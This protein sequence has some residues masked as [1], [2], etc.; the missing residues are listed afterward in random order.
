MD[1]EK[2]EVVGHAYGTSSFLNLIERIGSVGGATGDYNPDLVPCQNPALRQDIVDILTPEF[3][4]TLFEHSIFLAKQTIDLI[5]EIFEQGWIASDGRELPEFD[6]ELREKVIETASLAQIVNSA[7][8]LKFTLGETIKWEVMSS[9]YIYRRYANALKNIT[10]VYFQYPSN[11]L[12]YSEI[13][14]SNFAT[15]IV[16]FLT[17]H[18]AD[19]QRSNRFKTDMLSPDLTT[20]QKVI[21]RNA[22]QC[23]PRTHVNYPDGMPLLMKES[24]TA[25]EK[26]YLRFYELMFV[27]KGGVNKTMVIPDGLPKKVKVAAAKEYKRGMLS[28]GGI[29]SVTGVKVPDTFKELVTPIPD[30][31]LDVI[32]SHLSEDSKVT[33]QKIEGEAASGALGGEAPVVNKEEDDESVVRLKPILAEFLKDVYD[34]FFDIKSDDYEIEFKEEPDEVVGMDAEGTQDEDQTEAHSIGDDYVSYTVQMLPSGVYTYPE[35]EVKSD[36][37]SRDDV[38]AMCNRSVNSFYLEMD[39]SFRPDLVDI[40]EGIGHGAIVGYNE[41]TGAD[42]TKLYVKRAVASQIGKNIRVSPYFNKIQ[43]AGRK[44]LSVRNCAILKPTTKS[45]AEASGLFSGGTQDEES[46]ESE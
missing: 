46:E 13:T 1:N 25:L 10:E 15:E 28:L 29:I 17:Q 21:A 24:Q 12:L 7:Y 41:T 27:H 35:R 2:V 26:L 6:A 40:T 43:L 38:R 39:H 5:R 3:R 20:T 34:V 44:L 16:G 22:V 31:H 42:I 23:M 8:L 14:E 9:N 11:P 19:V 30:L 32:N 4:E 33:K 45:R 37:Y 36:Y 18:T